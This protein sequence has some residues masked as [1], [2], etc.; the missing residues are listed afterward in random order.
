MDASKTLFKQLKVFKDTD[1]AGK[2]P[3]QQLIEYCTNVLGVVE[4]V[5][6]DYKTKQDSR[7]SKPDDS[8]KKNLAKAVS[9][10]ANTGGGILIWGIEDK[11][12]VPKPKPI[13]DVQQFLAELLRLAPLT[14]DPIVGNIDGEWISSDQ[15]NGQGYALVFIPESLLPPHRVI[16]N[17]DYKDK[18]Y[19]RSGSDFIVAPHVVLEDMF[20]RR[21]KP[22]LELYAKVTTKDT[23]GSGDSRIAI[24]IIVVGIKNK[25]RGSAKSPFLSLSYKSPCNLVPL[26]M[27]TGSY[28][29]ETLSFTGE[30]N[31]MIYGSKEGIIH[32][33]F[34]KD[35]TAIRVEINM[36]ESGST[37]LK[38]KYIVAAEGIMPVEGEKVISRA[39]LLGT[40]P[41]LIN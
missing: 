33:G 36:V 18:Y 10:F 2:S 17:G 19:I 4:R 15:G 20:G 9:G 31:E 21:P 32:P 40:Q 1:A 3:E 5:H 29:S 28:K 35:I 12:L 37:Y 8:D 6:V 27:I 24:A 34:S 7:N 11:T 13:N 22:D 25:G 26:R 30:T 16:L 41:L 14:T 38:I 23:Q 39:E